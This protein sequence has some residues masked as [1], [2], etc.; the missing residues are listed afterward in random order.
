MTK[1]RAPLTFERAL[2]RI[3]DLIGW[4]G[5]GALIGKAARTVMDYSDPDTQTGVSLADAYA[6]EEAYR[7]AG[8]EGAP[9]SDCWR[10]RLQLA[11]QASCDST[12]QDH[13]VSIIKESAEATAAVA[14]A[15]RP[16][17]PL[18]DRAVARRELEESI[19]AQ[20]S[21]LAHLTKGAGPDATLER[22]DPGGSNP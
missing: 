15:S 17:A 13:L 11:E 9:I 8:G 18:E 4:D 12:L 6:L 22:A 10:A 5:M 3:A 7:L 19:N 20:M 16:G 1:V 14:I 21:T 2:V